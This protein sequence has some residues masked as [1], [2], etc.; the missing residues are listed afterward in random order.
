M[1]HPRIQRV[2]DWLR[3]VV[4]E[5]RHELTRWQA[6]ARFAYDLGRFGARQLSQDKAPQMAGALAF[7]T[8]FSLIPV[9]V[10]VTV[11]A[12]A[13]RGGESFLEMAREV[14][15]ALGLYRIVAPGATVEQTV[16]LGELLESLMQ[17]ATG[18]NLAALG[19]V[20]L[21][22]LVYAAI[23]LMVT[24][25]NSFNSICRAPE[26]RSWTSRLLLY[27]T[28]LTLGAVPI[29]LTL[30]VNSQVQGWLEGMT[31][32]QWVLTVANIVWSFV[33]VWLFMVAIYRLVPS[34]AV[35][36]R[37]IMIGAF[38]AAVLLKI[39]EESLGAYLKNLVSIQRLYGSLGLAPLFM[40]WVYLMWLI[41]LFGLEVAVTLHWLGGR[42]LEEMQERSRPTGLIDP[43]AVLAV[44]Q[45]VVERFDSSAG[46]T[47][48]HIAEATG[49]P[50]RTV[51]LMFERLVAAGILHR[52]DREDAAVALARPP[53]RVSGRELID[54]G[55]ELVSQGEGGRAETVLRRLRDAQRTLADELTLAGLRS[56]PSPATGSDQA[57]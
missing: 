23:S 45:V 48:S 4:H 30:Y 27:W 8:L 7:R 16:S 32:W 53:E 14:F 39:G 51:S 29:G 42:R 43:A 3:R 33:V 34:L 41:V 25:E 54:I 44:M 18:L 28:V 2:I 24:I 52:L 37:S 9:L 5:P 36:V 15:E 46:S 40:F 20:G 31:S 50:E 12:R 47:P 11:L 19:W 49:L 13:L 38:V 55:F 17:Q 35:G 6:M 21:A 56:A 22:V 57:G 1:P 10:V 26:G